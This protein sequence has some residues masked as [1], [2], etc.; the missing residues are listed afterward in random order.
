MTSMAPSTIV[1][2]IP[3]TTFLDYFVYVSSAVGIWFGVCFMSLEPSKLIKKQ[4]QEVKVPK[5]HPRLEL[6]VNHP[7]FTSV[8]TT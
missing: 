3:I 2:N 4:L 5:R 1:S 8:D 7:H 6:I